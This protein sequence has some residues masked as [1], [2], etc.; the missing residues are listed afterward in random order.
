MKKNGCRSLLNIVYV[1]NATGMFC[2]CS[3]PTILL[4]THLFFRNPHPL[5]SLCTLSLLPCRLFLTGCSHGR[6]LKRSAPGIRAICFKSPSQRSVTDI[7]PRPTSTNFL[8]KRPIRPGQLDASPLFYWD[9]MWHYN[10]TKQ[11]QNIGKPQIN[12]YTWKSNLMKTKI[13]VI[14]KRVN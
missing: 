7:R 3:S 11:N 1:D 2:F 9:I 4:C 6:L 12:N 8:N 14:Y 13:I 5:L 10:L